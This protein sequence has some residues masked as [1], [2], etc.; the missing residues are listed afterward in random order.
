MIIQKELL[1]AIPC[2][3]VG[4]RFNEWK[5]GYVQAG[6]DRE[7]ESTT[8]NTPATGT[9]FLWLHGRFSWKHCQY[10]CSLAL[11]VPLSML[12]YRNFRA[13]H[14]SKICH[15]KLGWDIEPYPFWN[16]RIDI[17]SWVLRVRSLTAGW[18]ST[19]QHIGAHL[20]QTSVHVHSPW[21]VYSC[22]PLEV[23]LSAI[24]G[25]PL[26]WTMLHFKLLRTDRKR[27]SWMLC[28]YFVRRFLLF[29]NKNTLAAH[30]T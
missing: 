23:S 14:R 12:L 27:T 13:F 25:I 20:E 29:S 16:F 17:L 15:H 8:W 3:A 19:R 4:Q 21:A 18:S 28:L 7:E 26:D 1:C 22:L 10:H 6:R 24:P 2:E 30:F 5:L 11:S 9:M